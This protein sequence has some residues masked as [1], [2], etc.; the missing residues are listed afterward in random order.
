MFLLK[1]L[2]ALRKASTRLS[3]L[4][5]KGSNYANP[6]PQ[7]SVS[8]LHG[9]RS[10]RMHV[11]LNCFSLRFFFFHTKHLFPQIQLQSG[12]YVYMLL[13]SSL[14][15]IHILIPVAYVMCLVSITLFFLFLSNFF[16]Y[17][18]RYLVFSFFF[19]SFIFFVYLLLPCVWKMFL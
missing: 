2:G 6:I 3:F 19:F 14:V 12:G 15:G 1:I 18:V 4:R 13:S 9:D 11:A 5:K 8:E 7:A 16:L 17:I 10:D